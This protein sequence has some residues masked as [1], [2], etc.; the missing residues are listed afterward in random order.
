MIIKSMCNLQK[1]IPKFGWFMMAY[2]KL[3][4]V[5]DNIK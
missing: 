3:G 1:V 4:I 5:L 2:E